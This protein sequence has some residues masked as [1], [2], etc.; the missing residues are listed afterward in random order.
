[1]FLPR[2]S[3]AIS[4]TGKSWPVVQVTWLMMMSRV[5]GVTSLAMRSTLP[6]RAHDVRLEEA[7][8]D[9]VALHPVE[10]GR[11]DGDVLVGRRDD[12]VALLERRG[13]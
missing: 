2:A 8:D 12:L 3:A 7:D 11:V 5:F 6:S 4:F 13:R 1:M 9:A 10:Q